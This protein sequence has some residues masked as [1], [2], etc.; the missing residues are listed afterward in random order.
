MPLLLLSRRAPL[1]RTLL[2]MD[3]LLE[4]GDLGLDEVL[5]Y[6]PSSNLPLLLA[7]A[8]GY[9]PG[10]AAR[11][12]ATPLGTGFRPGLVVAVLVAAGAEGVVERVFEALH[13]VRAIPCIPPRVV[14]A[15][16]LRLRLRLRLRQ[17]SFHL[18]AAAQEE[19]RRCA[20]A[21]CDRRWSG[22]SGAGLA[23]AGG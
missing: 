11:D 9:A 20:V 19:G 12:A 4:R 23:G 14:P 16:R 17:R 6:L 7:G 18:L 10:D 21:G 5:L 22:A 3:V 1:R 13:A 15:T 2:L 8:A